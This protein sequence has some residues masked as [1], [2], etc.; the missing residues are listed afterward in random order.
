[1]NWNVDSWYLRGAFWHVELGGWSMPS[2][3]QWDQPSDELDEAMHSKADCNSKLH[4]TIGVENLHYGF[5]DI[6]YD[7]T[8]KGLETEFLAGH[9]SQD[10][11]RGNAYIVWNPARDSIHCDMVS[12]LSDLIPLIQN[13]HKQT[14]IHSSPLA[15]SL[16]VT[17]WSHLSRRKETRNPLTGTNI[18]RH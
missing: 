15:R 18:G 4:M 1:M 12:M 8:L 11:H 10:K 3:V 7:R 9:F 2:S 5:V 6:I 16:S 17:I 14:N 13:P